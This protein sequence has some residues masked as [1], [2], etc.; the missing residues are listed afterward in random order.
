LEGKG[1]DLVST[2]DVFAK[3]YGITH[4]MLGRSRQ[5]WY[6]RL[7]RQSVV[8]RLQQTVDGVDMTVLGSKGPLD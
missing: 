5:P 7:L 1:K 3:E 4:I 8:D 2:I 6:R